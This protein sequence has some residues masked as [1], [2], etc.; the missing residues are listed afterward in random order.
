MNRFD[1]PFLIF[2]NFLVAPLL[3][4]VYS[5]MAS[6]VISLYTEGD[7]GKAL[8]EGRQLLKDHPTDPALLFYTGESAR[9][10]RYYPTAEVFFDQIPDNAKTG[11]LSE[12]NF[13][14]G[15]TKKSLGKYVEAVKYYM[16]YL[17]NHNDEDDLLMHLAKDEINHC[18][19]IIG[20]LD[21]NSKDLFAVNAVSQNI[22]TEYSEMAP[23]RYADKIYF[24]AVYPDEENKVNTSRIYSVIKDQQARLE[25]FNPTSDELHAAHIALMPDASKMFYTICEQQEGKAELRCEIWSRDRN[26][27]GGW[28]PSVKLPKHI[29]NRE[30]TMLHPTIGWDMFLKSYVL[31]F[32]SDRPGGEG[33][34][35]I[36]G[37]V[38][39]KDGQYSEPFNAPFNSPYDEVTPFF[40]MPTQTIFFS[41]NGFPG[42]GGFDIFRV[43]KV[44]EAQWELPINMGEPLN[45]IHDEYY[46]SYHTRTGKGYFASNRKCKEENPTARN[47]Q[48]DIFDATIYAE[49][50][51][52]AFNGLNETKLSLPNITIMDINQGTVQVLAPD[53]SGQYFACPIAADRLHHFAVFAEGYRPA[54]LIVSTKNLPYSEVVKKEVYLFEGEATA[55]EQ[56]EMEQYFDKA[57]VG[58][59]NAEIEALRSRLN[60]KVIKP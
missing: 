57:A 17:D 37:S 16:E 58:S 55:Q 12:A 15:Q 53:P 48:T 18:E 34:L 2:L 52:M 28:G 50:Q 31:Y 11:A 21:N 54:R 29:N 56:A 4:Q 30:A 3:S 23:L 43:T 8:D 35:D 42:V 38:I 45:T 59:G 20:K 26:Y 6:S 41:S 60:S 1:I 44:G 32:S 7:F 33:G 5:D 40:H 25:S 24:T 47:C 49:L 9:R 10:L 19:W 36:W 46:Y 22:N 14:I 51:L 27:E 39:D 13:F